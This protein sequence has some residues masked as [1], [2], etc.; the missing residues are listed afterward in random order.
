M[1]EK[2]AQEFLDALLPSFEALETQS[3]AILEFLKDKGIASDKDLAPYLDQAGKASNVRWRAVRIR[4]ERLLS[5]LLN[6]P[7]KAVQK[8]AEK[9]PGKPNEDKAETNPEKD[10]NTVAVANSEHATGEKEEVD[11]ADAKQDV[12]SSTPKGQDK[13]KQAGSKPD[14]KADDNNAA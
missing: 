5:S 4:M 13:S 3:S 9:A 10:K 8:T 1:D 6:P 2:I 7:E 12:A 11:D 14:E